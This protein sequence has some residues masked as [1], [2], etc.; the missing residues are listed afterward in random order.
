M[1]YQTYLAMWEM[2]FETYGLDECSTEY[3]VNFFDEVDVDILHDLRKK[4]N[5]LYH[6]D[7]IVEALIL[8]HG[9][10]LKPLYE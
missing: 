1:V 6:R 3:T 4:L 7:R 9:R 2:V 10:D 8:F 5:P